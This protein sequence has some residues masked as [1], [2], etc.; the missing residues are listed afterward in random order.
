MT[1]RLWLSVVCL[2]SGIGLRAVAV[3]TPLSADHVIQKA[4]ARTE[5]SVR[6]A[7]QP[8][9]AYTKVTLT[10]EL[11]AD[12]K[13]REHKE[14]VYQVCFRDGATEVKLVSV[15]GKPPSE[16]EL[17]KQAEKDSDTRQ[18]VG[19]SRRAKGDNRENLLTAEVVARF[20]FTLVDQ[21]TINDRLAYRISFVPKDPAPPVH[22]LAD[23]LMNRLS[24][25]VW[26]DAR[27]FEVAR[28]ELRLGSEVN[29]LGGILGSL[30]RFAF[31]ITRSRIAD[32]LWLN[33]SSSG[34]FEG[35]KLLDSLRIKTKSQSSNFR[36]LAMGSRLTGP[37]G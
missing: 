29:L 30:K 3:D 35:R 2:G 25:T 19:S 5:H 36:P 7:G 9:F 17:K 22:S 1:I 21:Q 18:L 33:T 11:G 12:G 27:E 20:D 4:V 37:R 15:N 28:A 16:A 6:K 23:R 34:D 8:A 10:E 13:V 32:G 31:T 14:R 24:G 26:I